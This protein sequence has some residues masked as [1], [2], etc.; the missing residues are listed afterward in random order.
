MVSAAEQGLWFLGQRV[1]LLLRSCWY[2]AL[3]SHVN[4]RL[5]RRIM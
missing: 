4:C 5:S 2:L 1:V 3:Y